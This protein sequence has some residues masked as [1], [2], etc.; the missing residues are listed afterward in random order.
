MEKSKLAA[1]TL[2]IILLSGCNTT[3]PEATPTQ[4]SNLPS[5][6]ADNQSSSLGPTASTTK[7]YKPATSLGPAENVPLP[8]MPSIAKGN[9]KESADAFAQYYFALIN[10]TVESNDPEP[11]KQN[12][13]RKCEVCGTAIIDP[14]GR[15]QITG[16]WQVGGKH[17]YKVI[18]SYKPSKDKA[19]V[20]V[21]FEVDAAEFYINPKELESRNPKTPSKV[22]ALSLKYDSGWKV[23]AVTFEET[24]Q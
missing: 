8:K 17:K 3:S 7:I 22:A 24:R 6:S 4:E 2:T 11:I 13:S 1:V 5:R 15:A 10:Y 16:K 19:I 18:D 9:S 14:A 12:S 21:R 23:D 20:S